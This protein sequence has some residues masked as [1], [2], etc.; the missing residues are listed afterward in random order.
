MS[1]GS[2][3]PAIDIMEQDIGNRIFYLG[4][5][6][7]EP[8]SSTTRNRNVIH[9]AAA[10]RCRFDEIYDA[11]SN[12]AENNDLEEP[13]SV[14]EMAPPAPELIGQKEALANKRKLKEMEKLM[15][16]QKS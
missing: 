1:I 9:N 4:D 10:K 7:D 2:T 5:K 6:D 15:E 8:A 13:S 3:S 12:G 11:Q 14:L 16:K